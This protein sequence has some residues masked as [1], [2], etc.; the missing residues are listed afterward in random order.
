MAI[1]IDIMVGNFIIDAV[2]QWELKK[3][4]KHLP[5][6]NTA[7]ISVNSETLF[8]K[9]FLLVLFNI[10]SSHQFKREE[11]IVDRIYSMILF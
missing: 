4:L 1:I 2:L 11:R 6:K 8:V 10:R 5:L 9:T 3:S 7:N